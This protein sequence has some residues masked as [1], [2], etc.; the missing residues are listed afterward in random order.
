M[1]ALVHFANNLFKL[2]L[3]WKDADRRVVLRFGFPSFAGAIA[4]AIALMILS[5]IGVLFHYSIGDKI[6]VVTPVGVII[7]LLLIVF[8]LFDMLPSGKRIELNLRYLP[9]G[10]LLSGFFG[11]LSGHQGALRTTFLIRAG[12]SKEAFIASGVMI[13]CI[14]DI[15]RL[16]VYFSQMNASLFSDQRNLLIAAVLAACAG[17]FAGNKLLKKMTIRTVERFVAAFLLLFAVL[18]IA[19][20]V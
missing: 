5:D 17:A 9:F 8:A 14:V 10:G 4:G 11:G 6:F 2:G 12:L 15:S 19:G 3:T 1:T 13:A 20:M 7:G 18:L 16:S